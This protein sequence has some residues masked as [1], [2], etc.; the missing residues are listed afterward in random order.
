MSEQLLQVVTPP[1]ASYS[2]EVLQVTPVTV[3]FS[4]HVWIVTNQDV[5]AGNA[6]EPQV[7]HGS[8]LQLHVSV[9]QL[10]VRAQHVLDGS[11]DLGKQ[12]DEL[13]VGGQ[14]Q[15]PSWHRAQVELGVQEVELDQRTKRTS[16]KNNQTT[17][18]LSFVKW[19]LE[20]T[21]SANPRRWG[22]QTP[23]G[24]NHQ[25]SPGFHG[26]QELEVP[27]KQDVKNTHTLWNQDPV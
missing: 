27:A 16:S 22:F 7:F 8:L 10:A 25:P 1:L 17:W 5:G 26:R 15:G 6:A 23:L 12:V 20:R 3:S 21:W 4:C 13:D 24:C 18:L 14:Q 2:S 11:F 19:S 9:A